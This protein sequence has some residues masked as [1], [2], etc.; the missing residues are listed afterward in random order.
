LELAGGAGALGFEVPEVAFLGGDAVV[1]LVDG[2][3]VG[4]AEPASSGEDLEV[5]VGFGQAVAAPEDHGVEPDHLG[6][7]ADGD[8]ADQG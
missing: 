8:G 6:L 5:G 2:G 4:A 3:L 7:V 1:G